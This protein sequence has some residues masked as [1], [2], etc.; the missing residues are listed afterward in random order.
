M[1]LAEE[2]KMLR[3]KKKKKRKPRS[4][5]KSSHYVN[6]DEFEALLDQYAADKN[7]QGVQLQL[8][9]IFT[10][11]T[12]RVYNMAVNNIFSKSGTIFPPPTQQDKEDIIQS[13]MWVAWRALKLDYWDNKKVNTETKQKTKAFNYF[14]CI[15]VYEIQ[16]FLKREIRK[17]WNR[18]AILSKNFAEK[19]VLKNNINIADIRKD[20]D[21]EIN[22]REPD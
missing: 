11:I 13:A 16:N 1:T 8:I 12:R 19:L 18:S 2:D 14:T 20:I 3:E 6:N 4:K 9:E 22:E 5:N 10:K 17:G 21:G 15:I 7:N